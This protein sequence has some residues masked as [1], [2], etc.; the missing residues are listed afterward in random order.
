ML[1]ED[2]C[3]KHRTCAILTLFSFSKTALD[4]FKSLWTILAA[5]SHYELNLHVLQSGANIMSSPNFD[6]PLKLVCGAPYVEVFPSKYSHRTLS[7]CK[8]FVEKE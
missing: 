2:Y 7:P 4:I 1:L 5:R 3:T 8:A 6:R